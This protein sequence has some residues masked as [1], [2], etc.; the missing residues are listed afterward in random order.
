MGREAADT[1]P[2]KKNDFQV[3]DKRTDSAKDLMNANGHLNVGSLRRLL[4]ALGEDSFESIALLERWI[5]SVNHDLIELG[6]FTPKELD[7]NMENYSRSAALS[8][9]M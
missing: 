5:A 7:A 4:E 3:C 6:N 1:T 9:A 2:G 8:E